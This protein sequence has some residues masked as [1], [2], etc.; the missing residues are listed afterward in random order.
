MF[1]VPWE[2]PR[3]PELQQ[4]LSPTELCEPDHPEIQK[5]RRLQPKL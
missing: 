3:D 5:Y 4:Y 1:E 2:A